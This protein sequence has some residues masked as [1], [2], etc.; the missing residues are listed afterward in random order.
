MISSVSI[1]RPWASIS[2]AV[3]RKRRRV[4][5]RVDDRDVER[6][7]GDAVA[8]AGAVGRGQQHEEDAAGRPTRPAATW[9]VTQKP[10]SSAL[11]P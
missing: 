7:I 9:R 4:E 5:A 2:D 3:A 8:V 6:L 11:G 1:S 10:P